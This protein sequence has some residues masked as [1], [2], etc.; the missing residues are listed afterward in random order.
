MARKLY[1]LAVLIAAA[2]IGV[3]GF[4][5][6]YFLLRGTWPGVPVALLWQTFFGPMPDSSSATFGWLL[7]WLGGVPLAAAGMALAYA[8]FL[9][10]DSLRRP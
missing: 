3:L 2:A 8:T 1:V 5:A 7:A 4:Q 9:A 10:S 6:L